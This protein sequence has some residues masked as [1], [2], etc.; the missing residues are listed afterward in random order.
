MLPLRFDNRAK[1]GFGLIAIIRLALLFSLANESMHENKSEQRSYRQK[2]Y[3]TSAYL[4][5]WMHKY[6]HN[7]ESDQRD[8]YSK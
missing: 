8:Y 6:F 4:S 7:E 3:F 1:N 2:T 5:I